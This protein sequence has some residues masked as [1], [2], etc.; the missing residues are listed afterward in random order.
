MGVVI[1]ASSVSIGGWVV[2]GPLGAAATTVLASRLLGQR[3]GWIAQLVAGLVGWTLGVIAAGLITDWRWSTLDMA[4]VAVV[5]GVLFTMVTA[6]VLDL[7]SPTGTFAHG[8][9]AAL[10]GH[11]GPVARARRGWATARR[12]RQITRLARTNGLIGHRVDASALPSGVRHTL[13]ESGGIFVKL[14]Q[15]AS[16]RSD[17]L[18]ATWC[19]E[20]ALLRSRAHPATAEEVRPVL[21]A[22]LGA[23]WEDRFAAF[24]WEPLAAASIAQVYAATTPD[25]TDVVVKVQR[26]GL[27]EVM[28][29]DSAAVLA[30]AGLLE[31]RTE[32]G[33]A[34]HPVDVATEFL[35]GVAEELDLRIEATNAAELRT[36]LAGRPGVRVPV[37]L[38][39]LSTRRVL[40]EER[41]DGVSIA[42]VDV[43]RSR[44][45]DPTELSHRLLELFLAQ[46]F[47]IGVFHADPHP[48]NILVG[49]DGEIVLID[50]GAVG[51]LGPGQRTA[52]MEILAAASAGD[53]VAVRQALER[54]VPVG[55]GV[56]VHALDFAIEDLLDRYDRTG[57]GISSQAFTDLV[58]VMARFDLRAPAWMG[59]LGRTL[60]TLEGTLRQ[61][62]P[63]FSLVDAAHAA[64]GD[65]V[66]GSLDAATLRSALEHE[67]MT[68]LPRLRRLPERVDDLLEQA[69]TGRFRASVSLFG[70]PD[71]ARTLTR[72]VNRLVMAVLAAALGLGSARLLDVAGGPV[73]GDVALNEVLGYMGLAAASVLTLRI[74]AGIA[75]DGG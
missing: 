19:E 71:D 61:I 14:G 12:Y 29:T 53:A 51:R 43:L 69:S 32:L 28:A 31:R 25:G 20:L 49:A 47:E 33:L 59:T 5:T 46:I 7:L 60:I 65:T 34:M 54:I 73:V 22:E 26:P 3:R 50:L 75:R 2:L 72:L 55:R 56:D 63:A 37:V 23:G 52:T 27:D 41:V 36:A 35:D 74:V 21:A 17:L 6:I 38:D 57:G 24:D 64:S 18:P 1:A 70:D 67:A 4:V 40:T 48:G 62:D 44:G 39:D 11:G 68:Q 16:T 66:R 13:E 42:E 10:I 15:V 30:L 9:P 8:V 58:V 45:Q